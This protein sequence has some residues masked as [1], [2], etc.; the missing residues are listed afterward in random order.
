MADNL[1]IAVNLTANDRQQVVENLYIRNFNFIQELVHTDP[2]LNFDTSERLAEALAGYINK[3]RGK[4]T[5]YAFREWIASIVLPVISFASIYQECGEYVRAS[6]RKVFA[7]SLDLGITDDLYRDAEQNTWVWT[8]QHLSELRDPAKSKAKTKTRLYSVAKFQALS[9]RK[10][11]LRAKER[12]SDVA[13]SR[14]GYDPQSYD[15]RFDIVIEPLVAVDGNADAYERR[16][17]V[18]A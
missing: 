11:L 15:G 12:F 14:I 16:E 10:S 9:I 2:T 8:W 13:I 6:I 5:D 18:G 4:H 7:T 17:T 3:Y 1:N